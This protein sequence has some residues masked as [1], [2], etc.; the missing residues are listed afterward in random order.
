MFIF[1]SE[2]VYVDFQEVRYKTLICSNDL[3]PWTPGKV[4]INAK[5][6]LGSEKFSR[7]LSQIRPRGS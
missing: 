7:V 5:G 1:I 2:Y 6:I 4:K 3:Q